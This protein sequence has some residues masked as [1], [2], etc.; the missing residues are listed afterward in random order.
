MYDDIIG[1]YMKDRS[2]SDLEKIHRDDRLDPSHFRLSLYIDWKP[3]G[4]H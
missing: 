2:P 3:T 4:D 1:S